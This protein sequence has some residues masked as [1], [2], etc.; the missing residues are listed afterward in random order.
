MNLRRISSKMWSGTWI[1]SI[2]SNKLPVYK[3][4]KNKY[5]IKKGHRQEEELMEKRENGYENVISWS[6]YNEMN[7]SPWKWY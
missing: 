5:K 1:K 4:E 6:Q 7:C 3:T 2:F